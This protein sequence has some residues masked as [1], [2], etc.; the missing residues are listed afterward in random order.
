MASVGFHS[1]GLDLS[2]A[3]TWHES[4]ADSGN[5]MSR[6]FCAACGTPLFS[7]AQARP[8]VIFVRAGSLDDP[9]LMAPVANI[10][11]AEAPQWAC[12][13]SELPALP[14]QPPPL[15]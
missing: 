4:N 6:G 2:G 15:V 11:T 13:N 12:L 3:V 8:Q 7:T 14:G 9:N 1:S 10:W 5:R